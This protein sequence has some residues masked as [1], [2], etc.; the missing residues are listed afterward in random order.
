MSIAQHPRERIREAID[1]W[2]DAIELWLEDGDAEASDYL[3]ACTQYVGLVFETE[4]YVVLV[5]ELAA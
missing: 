1:D 4:P 2:L 3:D 5:Q